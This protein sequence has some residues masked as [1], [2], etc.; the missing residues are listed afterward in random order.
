[1]ITPEQAAAEDAVHRVRLELERLI[2]KP[3]PIPPQVVSA[4]AS[5]LVSAVALAGGASVKHAEIA[6]IN[7]AT[8]IATDADAAKELGR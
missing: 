6:G 1:M 8:K 7:E 2:G 4:L 5:V 3:L